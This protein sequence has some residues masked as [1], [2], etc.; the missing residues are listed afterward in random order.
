MDSTTLHVLLVFFRH[1]DSLDFWLWRS[2]D[3]G[4]AAS[5][6]I[7]IDIAAPLR[8]PVDHDRRR[9][10]RAGLAKDPPTQHGLAAGPNL[11]RN[12]SGHCAVD[13]RSPARSSKSHWRSSSSRFPD[14]RFWQETA[15]TARRQPR[16]AFGLRVPGRR[17]RRRLRHERASTGCLRGDAALVS[18]ALPRNAAG[19]FPAREYR[20]DGR[21][22]VRGLWVPAVTHYYL[23]SLPVA[24]PAI[25]LGRFVNHRLR[26]DSFLV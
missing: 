6:R 11:S 25:F 22:L 12:S 9:R 18:P 23:I 2:A 3:C 14:T 5:P 15:R 1:L 24:V 21:I 4:A 20:R 7:P 8:S 26:G 13:Q 19:I 16:L 10:R 17:A